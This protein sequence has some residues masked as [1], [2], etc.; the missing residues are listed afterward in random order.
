[1]ILRVFSTFVDSVIIAFKKKK[2][3]HIKLVA[4]E[5]NAAE[6][7]PGI[8]N[9]FTQAASD[10]HVK[11]FQKD[12]FSTHPWYSRAGKKRMKEFE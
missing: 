2:K 5:R 3:T 10:Q 8:L 7:I 6:I 9:T 1:M 11:Y 12:F 4:W